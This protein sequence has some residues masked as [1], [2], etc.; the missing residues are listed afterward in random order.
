[1]RLNSIS[2]MHVLRYEFRAKCRRLNLFAMSVW[3]TTAS[4]ST[5]SIWNVSSCPSSVYT[6]GVLMRALAWDSP[7]VV[8]LWSVIMACLL[9]PAHQ[10]RG[11]LSLSLCQHSIGNKCH[12]VNNTLRL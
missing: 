10:G 8:V 5:K 3:Q 1:M 2:W 6:D 4:A 11:P 7:S 9:P 12:G